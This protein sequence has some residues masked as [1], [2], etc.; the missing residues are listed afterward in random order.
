MTNGCRISVHANIIDVPGTRE[1]RSLKMT[2]RYLFKVAAFNLP[3]W[4]LLTLVAMTVYHQ[5]AG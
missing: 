4:I 2:A 3:L 5:L 1:R